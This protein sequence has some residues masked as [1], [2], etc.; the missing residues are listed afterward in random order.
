MAGLRI[1]FFRLGG[2]SVAAMEVML[3]LCRELDLD[4]PLESLFAQ[5]TLG[6]LARVA[7][8]RI[9]ADVAE[10]PDAERRRLLADG[11]RPG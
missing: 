6:R 10:I 8:D 11:E 3:R 1:G 7:E 4:L 2:N 5:P 9:L